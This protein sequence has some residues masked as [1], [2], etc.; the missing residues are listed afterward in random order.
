MHARSISA[1]SALIIAS[2]ACAGGFPD[3][4]FTTDAYG[5]QADGTRVALGSGSYAVIDL[6]A[7]ASFETLRLLSLADMDISIDRGLFQHNDADPFGNW[8]ASYS[9]TGL[10]AM[11]GIDSFLTMGASAGSGDPF[12]AS[13]D[14][15]LNPAIPG[16]LESGGGWYNADPFNGQG[17]ASADLDIFVGRFV[18]AAPDVAGNAFRVSG[19]MSYNYGFPGVYFEDDSLVV[20]LP[21]TAVPGP[22]AL[23]V[24]AGIAAFRGRRR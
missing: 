8:S 4:R 5:A 9:R 22:A 12:A 14:P 10:G 11:N 24:L 20:T 16:S 7:T 2:Q 21:G 18:I 13:T 15:S 19:T 3:F 6:F 17:D 1:V 23:S